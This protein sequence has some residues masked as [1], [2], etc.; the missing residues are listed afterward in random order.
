MLSQAITT[1][2]LAPSAHTRTRF[3]S[4]WPVDEPAQRMNHA[5]DAF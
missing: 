5:A 2:L 4:C 1:I 3:V